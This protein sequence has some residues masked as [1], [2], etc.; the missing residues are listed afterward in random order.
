MFAYVHNIATVKT[1]VYI[2]A[3]TLSKSAVENMLYNAPRN[4]TEYMLS[5][6]LFFIFFFHSSYAYIL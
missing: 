5:S 4:I 6:L 1:L 2:T 3:D